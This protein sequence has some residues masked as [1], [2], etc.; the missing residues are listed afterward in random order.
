MNRS[1][2]LKEISGSFF[3]FEVVGSLLLFYSLPLE[4]CSYAA[5]FFGAV[6]AGY[7]VSLNC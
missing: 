2:F 1:F 6:T 5:K 3:P 4:Y 7:S